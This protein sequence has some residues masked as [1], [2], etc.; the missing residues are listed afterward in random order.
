MVV[1]G[2]LKK[3]LADSMAPIVTTIFTFAPAVGAVDAWVGAVAFAIE[4]YLDFSGYSDIARGSAQL[5]GYIVPVNFR[6]PYLSTTLQ[7]FWRRWHISLSSWLR[8]Y[9]Y[10]PLGGSRNGPNRTRLNLMITMA[11]GGL[12]HGAAWHFMAWGVAHGIALA[13]YGEIRPLV[14]RSLRNA[15]VWSRVISGWLVTQCT[16]LALWVVFRAPSLS[17]AGHMLIRMV[18][19]PWQAPAL[20]DLGMIAH[21]VILAAGLIGLE[22]GLRDHSFWQIADRTRWSALARPA[23]V[24]LMAIS[25]T[26]QSALLSVPVRFIYFQF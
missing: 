20:L 21:V 7:D 22:I 25:A 11:L 17:V 14:P 4:I 26:Y 19:G 24:T 2:L 18:S 3:T 9:L 12:W 23:L 5:F 6:S 10:I 13:T 16:V 15:P 8:D 1:G